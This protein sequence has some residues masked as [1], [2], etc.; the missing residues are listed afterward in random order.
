MGSELKPKLCELKNDSFLFPFPN[1][2]RTKGIRP[3]FKCAILTGEE[4]HVDSA[5]DL[6]SSDRIQ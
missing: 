1:Q 5:H 4:R 2:Y 6:I 3:P